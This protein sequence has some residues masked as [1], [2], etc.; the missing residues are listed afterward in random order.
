MSVDTDPG[1][2]PASV[3]ALIARAAHADARAER[4]LTAIAADLRADDA[5][6][7]DDRTR[8]AFSALLD[9][10]IET[11]RNEMAQ[12]A[13]RALRSAGDEA[14]AGALLDA[15]DNRLVA[16]RLLGDPAFVRE[17]D[18]RVR[19]DLIAAA[20]IPHER[21]DPD[22]P[23]LLPRLASDRDPLIAGP[24]MAL[25][26]ALSRRAAPHAGSPLARTDLS[27]EAHHR[28]VWTVAAALREVGA[29][30]SAVRGNALD[31]ALVAAAERNL[32]AHDEGI[33]LEASA[34]RLASALAS[35]GRGGAA[36]AVEALG[37]RLLTLFIA[38]A[39]EKL[40]LG[41]DAVREIVLDT[42][43]ARLWLMLRAIEMEREEIGRIGMALASADRR[44]SLDDVAAT[45]DMVARLDPQRAAA[46]FARERLPSPYREARAALAGSAR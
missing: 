46:A 21:D 1:R 30:L 18:G 33:G 36:L 38:A 43:G 34:V 9:S 11:V 8:A 22:A 31:Q 15:D 7:L 29:G 5:D 28:L 45:L 25:L 37:D 42:D 19:Q 24:A 2:E 6:R 17:L 27:A 14:V 13:A 12:H 23:T 40:G 44:R 32:A 4:R 41:Y 3:G 16:A 20:L 35:A 39:A 26:L 10:L